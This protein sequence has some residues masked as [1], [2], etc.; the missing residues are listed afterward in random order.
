MVSAWSFQNP[1]TW[2]ALV[3]PRGLSP[4]PSSHINLDLW[5]FYILNIKTNVSLFY[6]QIVPAWVT[7]LSHVFARGIFAREIFAGD[8]FSFFYS[9]KCPF[10]KHQLTWS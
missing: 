3:S 4:P 10:N 2:E 1:C 5:V 6:C 8:D 9:L 7:F